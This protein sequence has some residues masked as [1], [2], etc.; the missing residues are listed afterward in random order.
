MSRRSPILRLSV[1][2][3]ETLHMQQSKNYYYLLSS[4]VLHFSN[5]KALL[6]T[7]HKRATLER[8]YDE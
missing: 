3:D 7:L 1:S 8:W 5:V 4:V 6:V 2:P